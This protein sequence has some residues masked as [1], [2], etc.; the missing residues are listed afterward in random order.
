M[1]TPLLPD[2]VDYLIRRKFPGYKGYR[3]SEHRLMQLGLSRQPGIDGTDKVQSYRAELLAMPP[4][5]LQTLYSK[6]F[7]AEL[8]ALQVEAERRERG[9]FFSQP[10][11]KADF[12]HWSKTAHWTLD[13]A[14]ALS[15]GKAPEVV[16]W[17]TVKSHVEMSPFVAQYA[18]VRDL[19]LRAARAQQLYDPV[20]PG[21]FLAW[22]KR[23]DIA[24]P[25]ELEA[26]LVARGQQV[27]DWKS[28]YDELK[29]HHDELATTS[30]K[31]LADRD[32][33]LAALIQERDGLRRQ[34]DELRQAAASRAKDLST[35]ARE[36][37]L[38]LV[39]AMAIESY[40][41][42][43]QAERSNATSDIASD[44]DSL[45]LSLDPD[46]IRKWLNEAS[47]SLP[48]EEPK[49]S[50]TALPS[51]PAARIPARPPNRRPR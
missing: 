12:A 46:T 18:R 41:Y 27:A 26:Q 21:F 11:A 3:L 39:I 33:M 25:A 16:K 51:S 2:L 40:G 45:G 10:C 1:A 35:R 43:P 28:V 36:T 4:A 24:Y 38:K 17:E 19:V 37:L 8:A 42:D 7:A 13:E 30:Q 32:R 23:T 49:N 22:A 9:M 5:D 20:L 29:A 14:V 6:E 50:P 15:F 47:E 31:I 48:R 44:L 34:I